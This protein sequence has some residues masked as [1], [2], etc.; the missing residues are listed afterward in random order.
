MI[1]PILLGPDGPAKRETRAAAAWTLDEILR[2]LHP[3]MPF[4]TEELGRVTAEQ[5]S[6]RHHLLALDAWPA[7]DSL[8]DAA[9]EAEIGWVVDLVSAIRSLRAEM[10]IAPATLF[11][12]VLVGAT[13]QSRQRAERWAE[14]VQR[15]ARVADISFADVAPPGAVQLVVRGEVAALPLKGVIDLAAERARLAKE[16]AKCDADIA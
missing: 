2:L 8:D 6:K 3:F 15:L 14:F 10:N 11:P 7:H 1:K 13:A 16:M 5:G 4:V 9:A 12:L